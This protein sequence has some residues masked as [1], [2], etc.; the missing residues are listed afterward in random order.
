MRSGLASVVRKSSEIKRERPTCQ[1]DDV[2]ED[3]DRR[4]GRA[5]NE[6]ASGD[7]QDLSSSNR[8]SVGVSASGSAKVAHIFQ[9]TSEGEHQTTGLADKP[10]RRQVEGESHAGTAK[11]GSQRKSASVP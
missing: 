10:D 8:Q 4:D 9:D 3:L 2:A 1:S 6:V 7:E 11:E 5:E